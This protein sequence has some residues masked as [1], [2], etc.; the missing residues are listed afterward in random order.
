MIKIKHQLK[1]KLIIKICFPFILCFVLN[2]VNHNN[3]FD[4]ISHAIILA[5]GL[6]F[7]KLFT[8]EKITK[9]QTLYLAI[10]GALPV[11]WHYISNT[12]VYV[13]VFALLLILLTQ[14]KFKNRILAFLIIIGSFIFSLYANNLIIFPFKFLKEMLIFSDRWTN[15]AISTLQKEALYLPYKIRYLVFNKSVYIYSLIANVAELF[16]LK[17]LSDILLLANIYP[18]LAGFIKILK[19]PPEDKAIFYGYIISVLLA[20][21]LTRSANNLIP[22]LSLS[23]YFLLFI[24]TGFKEVNRKIYFLL[25]ILSLILLTS[26]VK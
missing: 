15:E 20:A 26:P 3:I 12:S 6:L 8:K 23:P 24:L 18:L 25:I 2:L 11:Y 4:A 16:T 14:F 1:P 17:N 9:I 19:T 5:L 10:L 7:Y 21:S 22:F 13:S